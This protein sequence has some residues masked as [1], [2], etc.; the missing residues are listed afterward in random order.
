MDE[1]FSEVT[2]EESAVVLSF[3]GAGGAGWFGSDIFW[4]RCIFTVGAENNCQEGVG[5][6]L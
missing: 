5:R 2:V 1:G 3:P 6:V 4:V